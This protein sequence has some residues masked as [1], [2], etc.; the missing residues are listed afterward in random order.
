M[1]IDWCDLAPNGAVIRPVRNLSPVNSFRYFD[2][3][4]SPQSKRGGRQGGIDA[5]ILIKT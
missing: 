5:N 3:E 1:Q 4:L 2:G